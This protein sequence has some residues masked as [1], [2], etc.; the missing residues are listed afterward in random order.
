MKK[1][2]AIVQQVINSGGRIRQ[3]TVYD[4]LPEK[5][6]ADV[7]SLAKKENIA[8]AAA[9]YLVLHK[10]NRPYCH[11][12]APVPM[13]MWPRTCRVFC[14]SKCAGA[15][16]NTDKKR[17][18]T[19]LQKYGVE[20]VRQDPKVAKKQKRTMLK[21]YGVTATAASPALRKKMEATLLKNHGV[22]HTFKSAAIMAKVRSTMLERYGVEHNLQSR[23]LLE[24]QQQAG[25]KMREIT[26]HGKT[27]R[28]RGYEPQVVEHLVKHVKVKVSNIMFT[29]AEGVP[30]V[31]YEYAG[32]KHV[33]HPDLL[34]KTKKG[35]VL[36]E[37]K[38]TYTAGILKRQSR[39]TFHR[40][41][42]KLRACEEQGWSTRFCI[43]DV[44]GNVVL[45][46]D[47]PLKTRAQ[48]RREFE[49]ALQA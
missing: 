45:I 13:P 44:K 33:Y 38:S 10:L 18:A 2:I 48:V 21:R 30:A 20:Y 47:A 24:R 27:F 3:H 43:V 28:L 40:V 16:P 35:D 41:M 37:V 22:T 5:L 15:D 34:V 36:I 25:F 11:C 23:E 17:R 32:R 1:F 26:L 9:L 12:G 42:T 31:P 46:K 49:A 19:N 6:V 29:A 4:H 39:T 8:R 14:S 7:D